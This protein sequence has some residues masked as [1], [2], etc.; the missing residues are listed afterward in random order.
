MDTTEGEVIEDKFSKTKGETSTAASTEEV[1]RVFRAIYCQRHQVYEHG[2]PRCRCTVESGCIGLAEDSSG[3][4][5]QSS[6][7][8]LQGLRTSTDTREIRACPDY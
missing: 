7:S 8:N 1:A 3:V 6:D 4:Q 2:L 5:E